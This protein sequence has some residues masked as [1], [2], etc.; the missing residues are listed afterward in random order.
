[1]CL[2]N[3][4]LTLFTFKLALGQNGEQFLYNGGFGFDLITT[5]SLNQESMSFKRTLNL[6]HINPLGNEL[7]KSLDAYRAICIKYH[8]EAAF[9]KQVKINSL[10]TVYGLKSD[11][12]YTLGVHTSFFI[13]GST[14]TA[15]AQGACTSHSGRLPEFR[16]NVQQVIKLM[17]IKH[18]ITSIPVNLQLNGSNLVF[19]SDQSSIASNPFDY[20][21]LPINHSFHKFSISG[22][23]LYDQVRIIKDLTPVVDD[24]HT[25]NPTLRYYSFNISNFQP[26]V[27]EIDNPSSMIG[28]NSATDILHSWLDVSCGQDL[29]A[30]TA[31]VKHTLQEITSVTN[32]SFVTP[33]NVDMAI[34]LAK[35]DYLGRTP[36]IKVNLVQNIAN[37]NDP[38]PIKKTTPKPKPNPFRGTRQTEEQA[39]MELL[40]NITN[41]E[42]AS[43]F[44][45]P[46]FPTI[47]TGDFIEYFSLGLVN[48][49][50]IKYNYQKVAFLHNYKFA[51]NPY[52][53]L[54]NE[55]EY[56]FLTGF[57]DM[58]T[59]GL[60]SDLT[61]DAP[62]LPTLTQLNNV[63]NEINTVIINQNQIERSVKFIG[64]SIAALHNK[65][66]GHMYASALYTAIQDTKFNINL[67]T[68]III[69]F[70]NKLANVIL[71]AQSG[72]TSM[73]A[74]NK[75]ELEQI[76]QLVRNENKDIIL[77]K[78]ISEVS[79]TIVHDG[80]KHLVL[81]FTI[82]ITNKQNL[83]NFYRV[84]PVPKFSNN[85]TYL[86][87]YEHSNLAIS[88]NNEFYTILSDLELTHCLDEPND[89]KSTSPLQ[90]F[91]DTRFHCIISSFSFNT[92]SCPMQLTHEHPSPF[93]YFSD[94]Q[95]LY[96]V[97]NTTSV[98][99]ICMND[100]DRIMYNFELYN[101]GIHTLTPGCKYTFT[102]NQHSVV[103]FTSSKHVT[104][105]IT[106][107]Q[108]F[109]NLS[110]K[111]AS[112]NVTVLLPNEIVTSNVNLTL[113]TINLPNWDD[114]LKEAFHP[115]KSVPHWI[116]LIIITVVF[117]ICALIIKVMYILGLCTYK[118]KRSSHTYSTRHSQ[119]R[120]LPDIPEEPKFSP[121][122]FHRFTIPDFP[123]SN[124]AET[125]NSSVSNP[126]SPNFTTFRTIPLLDMKM[127]TASMSNI[128]EAKFDDD[129]NFT[130]PLP[131]KFKPSLSPVNESYVEMEPL[132][133]KKK[134]L[135]EKLANVDTITVTDNSCENPIYSSPK[136]SHSPRF[137]LT[138][139]VIHTIERQSTAFDTSHI[140]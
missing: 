136:P 51:D 49:S 61:L 26:I 89:C 85:S 96:S 73:Y 133:L 132:F 70:I 83:F 9:R 90:L 27:C 34:K 79:S 62:A 128:E 42:P 63:I 77:T 98:D 46:E 52:F 14:Y 110:L 86:P 75:I 13:P 39:D 48:V 93:L 81:I 69:N 129:N 137:H 55:I 36:A 30:I 60:N 29:D 56:H 35:S 123:T 66:N 4:L 135:D 24:C 23:I 127:L 113:N 121:R 95:T 115:K 37:F 45:I 117:I 78:K 82:P 15:Y 119:N 114:L 57:H 108:T 104:R 97:P 105:S 139:A 112:K 2:I 91:N 99:Y 44:E 116:Q 33:F 38:I 58:L 12:L 134:E 6:D 92:L 126:E 17:C 118:C 106:N 130:P 84:I 94:I 107:W 100:N 50:R 74:L 54:G 18:N 68:Q 21:E 43:L 102:C 8:D 72:K 111:F 125:P 25:D 87:L 10:R 140:V 109:E 19:P 124:T 67:A 120:P 40:S 131:K 32:F 101:S 76:A 64:S 65:L 22:Q 122:N 103:R 53:D 41:S 1:M 28:H 59:A 80:H 5:T 31:Q 88:V 3:I 7:D 138:P 11:M 20:V 16:K 71:A 47:T